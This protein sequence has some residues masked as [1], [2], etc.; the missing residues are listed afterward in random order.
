MGGGGG[1][2]EGN[3]GGS[4]DAGNGGG[5]VFIFADTIETTV[6]SSYEISANG[7]SVTTSSGN[8]GN[9]G[10]G[11]GG[12]IVIQVNEWDISGTCPLIVESNG[13]KG[14]DAITAN[15]H[16]GGGGGGQGAVIY[17]IT[18][19]TAN[20]T[21]N[22]NNGA[23][24]LNCSSCSTA[25]SG[26]NSNGSGIIDST[27][28]P[29]PVELIYF[30]AQRL[31]DSAVRLNWTTASELNNSHFEIE[32]S[33]D[34]I[35]F[36]YLDRVEGV[37]TTSQMTN[38]QYNDF[39]LPKRLTQTACYRLKQIDFGGSSEQTDVV[40]ID[41]SD[42][43]KTEISF[44]PNPTTGHLIITSFKENKENAK[45]KVYDIQGREMYNFKVIENGIDLSQLN[46]G[47]YLVQVV[48]GQERFHHRIILK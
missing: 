18:E 35:V 25:D 47:T 31:E 5:I 30:K 36:R 40:C 37:G 8:D 10:G 1:A 39:L 11:A 32:R 42:M 15:E 38:Y 24:G 2:G 34:G 27:N 21:T 43:A 7:Q 48:I 14:G 26:T 13:G 6:C 29:L 19:P 46:S 44:Y 28:T 20:T 22:T 17:S 41:L 12:S 45:I 3:N 23:G 33:L 4:Q 16:G 9:S